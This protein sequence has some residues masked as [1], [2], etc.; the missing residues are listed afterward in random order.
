MNRSKIRW[1]RVIV[2]IVGGVLLCSLSC[3]AVIFFAPSIRKATRGLAWNTDPV[4]AAQVAHTMVDYDLPPGCQ[5]LKS[6][7]VMGEVTVIIGCPDAADLQIA[8]QRTAIDVAG[9]EWQTEMED[10][11]AEE[12]GDY[13]YQTQRV[14][15]QL[16]TIRGTDVTFSVREGTNENKQPVRMIMGLFP[17]QGGDVLLIIVGRSDIWDETLVENFFQSIR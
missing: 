6:M 11:W 15:T 16:S 9:T 3:A 2:L 4:V 7:E 10:V 17:G 14:G 12:V 1:R 13:T 5:E 8:L